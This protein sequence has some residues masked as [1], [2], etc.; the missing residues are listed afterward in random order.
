VLEARAISARPSASGPASVSVPPQR[1]PGE[2]GAAG[3]AVARRGAQR[4]D[5]L[6]PRLAADAATPIANRAIGYLV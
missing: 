5:E 6:E 3:G 1:L 4:R 2:P